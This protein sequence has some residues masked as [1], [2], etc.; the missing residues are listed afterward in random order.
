MTKLEY[1]TL[2]LE[3]VRLKMEICTSQLRG[4]ELEARLY[5]AETSE[6]AEARAAHVESIR[7]LLLIYEEH[8]ARAE[9]DLACAEREAADVHA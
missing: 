6:L 7:A 5:P 4:L 3:H 1:S 9:G 8:L 2:R